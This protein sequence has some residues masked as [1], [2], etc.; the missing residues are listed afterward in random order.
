MSVR[1]LRPLLALVLLA[2]LGACTL[3]DIPTFSANRFEAPELKA[4]R[5]QLDG[6]GFSK[7]YVDGHVEGCGT[8]YKSAGDR[9][10]YWEKDGPTL[11]DRDYL[12]GWNVGF[13]LCKGKYTNY[14]TDA[15]FVKP[16]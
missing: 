16:Q 11:S 2:S 4:D 13:A 8:G 10:F 9:D 14:G 15:T 6:K 3:P 12:A 1:R 7:A 5:A